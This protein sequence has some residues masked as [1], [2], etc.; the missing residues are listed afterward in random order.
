MTRYPQFC[1]LAR[2]AELVAERWTLLVVRELLLG[3]RR[4]VDLRERL[5]GVSPSVLT[6]RLARAVAVGLVRRRE[7]P[8]P[9]ATT[10]YELT[11]HGQALRP[12]VHELIRWGGR[13]LLPM[14]RGDRMEPEWMRLALA[15]CARHGPSPA[16]SF[17]LRVT[18]RNAPEATLR[19]AG[20]PGG[21]VVDDREGPA[22][23][24]IVCDVPTVLDLMRGGLDPEVAIRKRRIVVS[25]NRA[26]VREFS[27]LF[28]VTS[29][30]PGSDRPA[31]KEA[32]P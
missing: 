1:A 18:A 32:R 28:D 15:A 7:L 22:D 24:T 5:D 20:G 31:P 9:A 13:F 17:R 2:A 30:P 8:A 16:R 4:F 12:A 29:S 14:R 23:A 10:V 6:A 27:R 21:T 26:A 25:G 3:P 11:E 19:V